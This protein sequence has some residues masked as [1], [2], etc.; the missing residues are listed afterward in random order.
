M[1]S[2][3]YKLRVFVGS[4]LFTVG[5]VIL[6][7][8]FA[9]MARFLR[10]IKYRWHYLIISQAPKLALRWLSITCGVRWDVSGLEHIPQQPTV[11]LV[12]HQSTWE[13][14]V[15]PFLF[16][17][18]TWVIKKQLLK[19]PVFGCLLSAFHPIAIDR[20]HPRK[21][22]GQLLEQGKQ[23]LTD[24]CWVVIFPEGTRVAAGEYR[25]YKTGGVTLA[26][27]VGKPVLPIAHDA[28]KCWPRH[29]F[30]KYPGTIHV[31]I[32]E[33]IE[34]TNRSID[35]ANKEVEKWIETT[36]ARLAKS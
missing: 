30:L 15:V 27:E 36:V 8:V 20:S 3:L 12:K 32:G 11:V 18:V 14:L 10:A 23:R 29:G 34:T 33:L 17:P 6:I 2:I 31:V 16:C 28:G 24:G 26:R 5:L 4:C 35:E 1:Y 9:L 22:L 25:R 7:I 21:A 13:T 19:I